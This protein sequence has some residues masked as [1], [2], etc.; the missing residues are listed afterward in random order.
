MI[1]KKNIKILFVLL[2]VLSSVIFT[3]QTKAQQPYVSMQVFYDQLSPY[4]QWVDYPSYG[5]VWIPDA[6]YDFVPYSTNGHWILTEYGWTW[7]SNYNWGWA[8]FHYGRWDYNNYYGWFW[9]PDNEWGPSWVVWRSAG[10][11]YG[12]TPMRP[13]VSINVSF[14][15][16]YD[17]H[18]DH[19]IFVRNRDIMRSNIHRYHVNRNEHERIIRN[20]RVIENTYDD[21]GRNARYVAGPDR[22]DVQRATGRQIRAVGIQENNNPGHKLNKGQLHIYR[23]QINNHNDRD[24]RAAPSRV[25]NLKDVKKPSERNKNNRQHNVNQ[26]ENNKRQQQPGSVKSSKQKNNEQVRD[27]RDK[28]SKKPKSEGR[29]KRNN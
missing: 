8:A 9:I 2:V 20:S 16:N 22:N 29:K 5:Y 19:W 25:S 28:K 7:Y 17:S 3:N 13:G 12:W 1:M 18:N 27:E 26:R 11:Y 4:G 24:Q 23:P 10:D 14:G 6:G 15:N 21:R